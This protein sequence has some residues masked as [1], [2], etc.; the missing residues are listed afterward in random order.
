M[1]IV[2]NFPDSLLQD[3]EFA[4][5][6]VQVRGGYVLHIGTMEGTLALGDTVTC[7]IDAVGYM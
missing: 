5:K 2:M 7:A 4:V 6:D 3:V 1:R